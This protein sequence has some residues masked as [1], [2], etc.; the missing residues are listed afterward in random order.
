MKWRRRRPS[1][2]ADEAHS[3]EAEEPPSSEADPANA[4]YVHLALDGGILAIRGDTGEQLWVDREGLHRELARTRER[5][6]TLLYSREGGEQEPPRHIEE[7]FREVLEYELPI[8]L[9]E[10]PHPQALVPPSE[11]QT[12]LRD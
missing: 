12:L 10:Q 6:G 2:P 4:L 11:R 7:A 8:R 1:E 9:L 3:R 5:G